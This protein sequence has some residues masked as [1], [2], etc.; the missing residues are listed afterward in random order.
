MV[1]CLL[2]GGK[3]SVPFYDGDANRWLVA[4]MTGAEFMNG[5]KPGSSVDLGLVYDAK[6]DVV[7]GVLCSLRGTGA[8]NAVRVDKATL[9]ARPLS[10]VEPPTAAEVKP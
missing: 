5:G 9:H 1:G 4:E 2:P 10:P 3:P 6:R 8:L 7:W